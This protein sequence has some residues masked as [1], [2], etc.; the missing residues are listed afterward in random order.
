MSSKQQVAC[1]KG[2]SSGSVAAG[3]LLST[4]YFL[5]QPEVAR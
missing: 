1:N 5:L 4:Y 3:L 2:F